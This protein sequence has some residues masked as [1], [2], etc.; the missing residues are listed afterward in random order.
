[1]VTMVVP[2]EPRISPAYA[3]IRNSIL[4][5]CRWLNSIGTWRGER[6]NEGDFDA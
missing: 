2:S 4:H 3:G 5:H 1:M 6:F